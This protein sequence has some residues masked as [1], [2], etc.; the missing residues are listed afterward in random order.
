MIPRARRNDSG[1]G[2]NRAGLI[3]LRAIGDNLRD[4][5]HGH[6]ISLFK[7][8]SLVA[9]RGRPWAVMAKSEA[10]SGLAGMVHRASGDQAGAAADG[11]QASEGL[12][13]AGRGINSGKV[14]VHRLAIL[15]DQAC[16]TT[17]SATI[18]DRILALMHDHS[19]RAS[20]D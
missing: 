5:G 20:P 1:H 2:T 4:S 10:S 7:N 6:D 19:S 18:P 8:R 12:G 17:I 15:A 11:E 14:G 3:P 16:L 9:S 13:R